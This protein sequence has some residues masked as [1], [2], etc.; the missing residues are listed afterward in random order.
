M[1]PNEADAASPALR[2]TVCYALPQRQTLL[3]CRVPPGAT[4]ADALRASNIQ[5]LHPE[6]DL[7]TCKLGVF[8]KLAQLQTPLADLDR[9]ELYRP[10]TVDPKVARQRRVEK[11]RAAGSREG[12]KWQAKE[13]R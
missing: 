3:E 12:R 11:I 4:V 13:T 2:V 5:A 6:L 10:L 7:A 1:G 9:V 8:G